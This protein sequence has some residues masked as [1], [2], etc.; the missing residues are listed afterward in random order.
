MARV[1]WPAREIF[2]LDEVI[3][4][5]PC[6]VKWSNAMRFDPSEREGKCL[7][8]TLVYQRKLRS[9]F[10]SVVPNDKNTW[11]YVQ[12]SSHGVAFYKSQKLMVFDR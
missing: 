3:G 7:H 9:S 12:I 8:F 1:E 5:L 4:Y 2:T 6:N 10:L 11:Y